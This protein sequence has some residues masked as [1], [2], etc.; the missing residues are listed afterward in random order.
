MTVRARIDRHFAELSAS[1]RRIAKLVAARYPVSAL[2]GI[3]D[4]ARQA[5]VSAPTV[6]RFVKRLG[7]ARFAEF[8]RAIRGEVQD[9]ETSP[10][11]LFD[12][13]RAAPPRRGL[14][15]DLTDSLAA[16][17]AEPAASG[18]RQA[19]ELIA[20]TRGR[21]LAL[22][23]RWSSVA[24]QYLAFQLATLRGEVHALTPPPSGV[25][26]DRLVD[27]GRRD[28]LV[29]YDFRR[30]QDDLLG[31]AEVARGR[32]ARVVLVTDP[33]LSPICTPAEATIPVPVATTSPLDTLVP[34][35]AATD[36]VLA[37]LVDT[38]SDDAPRR[39]RRLEEA[40]RQVAGR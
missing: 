2:G 9:A 27:L 5:E 7:F 1:E 33:G 34:A 37:R 25:L 21:V 24:A 28:V 29:V 30:Y 20:G 19:V 18:I 39:M 32:G 26:A 22:G 4:I 11:E 14:V 23:G 35:L 3:E 8:Q 13:H 38:Y 17:E 40:R 6:T 16:V 10:L 15:A 31:A 12:R 36:A